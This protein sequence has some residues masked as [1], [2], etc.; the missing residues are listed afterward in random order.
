LLAPVELPNHEGTVA[1]VIEH[2][3]D[4]SKINPFLPVMLANSASLVDG[5]IKE[6]PGRHLAVMLRPCEL[7]A[8]IELQKRSRVRFPKPLDGNHHKSLVIF[9]VDCPGTFSFSE[10]IRHVEEKRDDAKMIKVALSFGTLENYAPDQMRAACQMCASPAPLGADITIGCIG[11]TQRGYLL[12]IA[13]DEEIN[14]SLKLADVTDGIASESEIVYREIV[15]GKLAEIKSKLMAD[16]IGKQTRQE[17]EVNSALALFA[18][19]T[20]CADCL[21]ACPLYDGELAGMLGVKEAHQQTHPL[22]TE[23][24]SVSRWLA[25]CSGCGLC[26]EACEHGVSLTPIIAALSHRIQHELHYKP[27]DPTQ[28]LPWTF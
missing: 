26:Q 15:I 16:L 12:A 11:A 27:G 5:F 22:L 20:L 3:D 6:H 14:A 24:V 28:R 10:Y 4:L 23:L 8:L 17:E 13:A 7:R 19:C 18:R 21:D 2:P 25:S 1:Q 9:G